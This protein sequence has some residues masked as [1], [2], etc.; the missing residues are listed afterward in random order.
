M[1]SDSCFLIDSKNKKKIHKTEP[2]LIAKIF[3]SPEGRHHDNITVKPHVSIVVSL[4]HI[5]SSNVV[6]PP[7]LNP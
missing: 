6:E 2:I 4:L 3:P 1:Y 5:V 7:L